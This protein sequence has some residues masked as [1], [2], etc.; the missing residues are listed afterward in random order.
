M[1]LS[2]F[3]VSLLPKVRQLGEGS[4]SWSLI[5]KRRSWQVRILWDIIR[6]VTHTQLERIDRRILVAS[7]CGSGT[8]LLQ[9]KDVFSLLR[10]AVGVLLGE[11]SGRSNDE[12]YSAS[13]PASLSCS[14]FCCTKSLICGSKFGAC[15]SK[16]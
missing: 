5:L 6:K 13:E 8:D 3:G 1:P 12:L 2:F 9:G 10:G 16:G 7:K 4:A 15:I 11:C 14:F